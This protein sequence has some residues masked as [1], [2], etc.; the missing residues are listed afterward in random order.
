MDLL[1]TLM[2][3]MTQLHIYFIFLTLKLSRQYGCF[4][5]IHTDA[6]FTFT[7]FFAQYLL[8][9]KCSLAGMSEQHHRNAFSP[10][11]FLNSEKNNAKKL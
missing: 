6:M 4:S 3:A 10:F 8:S 7:V 2:Y 9:F 11:F 1:E 5:A